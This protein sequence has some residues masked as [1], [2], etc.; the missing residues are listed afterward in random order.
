MIRVRSVRTRYDPPTGSGPRSTAAQSA[1]CV[2]KVG[3][4]ASSEVAKGTVSGGTGAAIKGIP[5]GSKFSETL[6]ISSKAVL[7]LFPDTKVTI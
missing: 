1:A 5:K 7:S 4:G 2:K 3:K 6:C